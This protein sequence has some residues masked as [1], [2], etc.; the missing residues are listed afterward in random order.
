M[1]LKNLSFIALVVACAVVVK[2]NP[3]PQFGY[4]THWNPPTTGT[5]SA[6][7]PGTTTCI[8]FDFPGSGS[9]TTTTT[10]TP[11]PTFTSV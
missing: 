7:D 3:I 4:T 11:Y 9:T 8:T 5:E 10:Y 6:A 2:C 1:V